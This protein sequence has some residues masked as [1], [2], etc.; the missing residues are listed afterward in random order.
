MGLRRGETEEEEEKK[1]KSVHQERLPGLSPKDYYPTTG[2]W[3]TWC[4][5]SEDTESKGAPEEEGRED[6]IILHV[7]GTDACI[8][9]CVLKASEIH[10]HNT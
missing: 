5:H 3:D 1:E 2:A 7:D 10:T 9:M 8:T 6:K 4:C